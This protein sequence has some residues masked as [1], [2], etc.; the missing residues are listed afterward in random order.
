MSRQRRIT[1]LIASMLGSSFQGGLIMAATLTGKAP[2]ANGPSVVWAEP[3]DSKSISAPS[4][5]VSITQEGLLFKPHVTVIPVGTSVDFQ[6][7]DKVAHNIFWPSVAGNKKMSHNLG[8]WPT[9]QSRSFTFD[10][11]GIVP[12]LC[13]VHSEMS[14][15]IVV[16]PTPYYAMTDDSGNYTLSN[17]PD[18]QYKVSVWHEGMKVNTKTVSVT[19]D[20]KVDFALLK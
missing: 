15:Y 2:A 18:G 11:P 1:L 3:V 5:S 12:L 9:G 13:N 14:A 4:K 19:S 16:V 6:N 8:T 10:T 17:I 7:H 20:A